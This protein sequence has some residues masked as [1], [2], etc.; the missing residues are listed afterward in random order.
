MKLEKTLAPVETKSIIKNE[1]LKIQMS[2]KDWEAENYYSKDFDW[3]QLKEEVESYP[4]LQFHL[5]IR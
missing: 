5:Y 3:D 1:K 4:C 2:G